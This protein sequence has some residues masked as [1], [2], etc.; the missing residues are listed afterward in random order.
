LRQAVLTTLHEGSKRLLGTYLRA[1][2][3]YPDGCT[4]GETVRDPRTGAILA[5]VPPLPGDGLP[6]LEGDNYDVF[7]ALARRLIE[8]S[9]AQDQSLEELFASARQV[10]TEADEYLV[11]A[12]WVDE[13]TSS[14]VASPGISLPPGDIVSTWQAVFDRPADGLPESEQAPACASAANVVTFEELARLV[15]RLK[16]RRKTAPGAQLLPCEQ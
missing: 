8:P 3:A 2:L 4:R 5:T 7:L 10:G 13:A 14:A 11:D 16:P 9:S 15:Q 12:D 6:A 1:L